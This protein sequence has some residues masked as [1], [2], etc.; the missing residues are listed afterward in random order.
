MT[1]YQIIGGL[2]GMQFVPGITDKQNSGLSYIPD[3]ALPLIII[4]ILFPFCF[5]QLVA[6]KTHYN[7]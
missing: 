3:N 7:L 2:H 4:I 5:S 6:Y 1:M